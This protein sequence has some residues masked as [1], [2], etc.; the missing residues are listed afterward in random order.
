MIT[1]FMTQTWK[2]A[3]AV[4][5][6]AI[7]VGGGI[8]LWPKKN[9]PSK[10]SSAAIDTQVT[11]V[12]SGTTYKG[13]TYQITYPKGWTHK[14]TDIGSD[15][16]FKGDVPSDANFFSANQTS[17]AIVEPPTATDQGMCLTKISEKTLTTKNGLTFT[18]TF[19]AN[20]KKEAVC[21]DAFDHDFVQVFIG[22]SLNKWMYFTFIPTDT[23]AEKDL[24]DLLQSIQVE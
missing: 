21:K 14:N 4:V 12:N 1:K 18:L 15:F 3:I 7:V 22:N 5:I 9:P 11:A 13:D 6:A 20:D 24:E 17:L 10:P 2:I 19:N 23:Q 8:Y 16:F